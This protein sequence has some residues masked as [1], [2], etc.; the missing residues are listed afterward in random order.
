MLELKILPISS[1]VSGLLVH[2]G[3]PSD[4]QPV[5]VRQLSE[6]G[7]NSQGSFELILSHGD[8]RKFHAKLVTRTDPDLVNIKGVMERHPEMLKDKRLTLP[9]AFIESGECENVLVVSPWID[10][11][12]TLADA[13][14][15]FQLHG[16]IRGARELSR[17]FGEFLTSWIRDYAEQ[18][19]HSDCTPTNVLITKE[20]D[21]VLVDCLGIDDSL[22]NDDVNSFIRTIDFMAPIW[23]QDFAIQVYEG[24][25]SGLVTTSL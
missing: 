18:I 14:M 9:F 3:L 13:L 8:D 23:S 15:N 12:Y 17:Q 10:H 22:P 6:S 5:T 1:Y 19:S 25:V 7:G 20:G 21:F 11:K 16:D 24:F 4:H 2:L